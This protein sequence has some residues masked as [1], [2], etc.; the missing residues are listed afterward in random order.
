MTSEALELLKYP[1]GK[2]RFVPPTSEN[3]IQKM[4]EDIA[5]LPT[6]LI[7]ATKSMN[8]Q[9]LNTPYRP[10]GWTVRQLIHHI[11]D[12][13]MNSYIRFK[14]AATENSP[15]I[16]TY[17]EQL[18]AEL[19]DGKD[20]PISLSIALLTALHERWVWFIKSLS[21]A[22]LQQMVFLHPANGA[23]S[24]EKALAMYAWHSNHHLRHI[25]DLRVRLNF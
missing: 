13:H 25:T 18:W 10:D 1:I 6:R 19:A 7:D 23:M 15:T 20:A 2:F 3:E 5:Q 17:E 9:Q 8:E 24:L 22:Q 16:T 14:L 12:S 21:I 11:A 4:I